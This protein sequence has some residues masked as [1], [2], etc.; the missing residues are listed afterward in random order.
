MARAFVH[1]AKVQKQKST[2]R[3]ILGELFFVKQT[4]E[5]GNERK[6]NEEITNDFHDRKHT[7]SETF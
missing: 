6:K 5:N 1:S 2:Y 4:N 3:F 7:Q